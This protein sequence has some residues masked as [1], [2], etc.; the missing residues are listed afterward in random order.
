MG[1]SVPIEQAR[2]QSLTL[3]LRNLKLRKG[4]DEMSN[5]EEETDNS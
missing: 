1:R 2:R 4:G 3:V 5:D